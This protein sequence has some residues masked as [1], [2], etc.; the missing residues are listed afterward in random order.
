M[1][2][3][4]VDD[5]GPSLLPPSNH[6]SLTWT[7]KLEGCPWYLL[8]KSTNFEWYVSSFNNPK[9]WQIGRKSANIQIATMQ[10]KFLIT[11]KSLI[12][13]PFIVFL[14][15]IFIALIPQCRI[16]VKLNFEPF[17]WTQSHFDITSYSRNGFI[18]WNIVFL[19]YFRRVHWL[20]RSVHQ[21]V[22]ALGFYEPA[23]KTAFMANEKKSSNAPLECIL[24][25]NSKALENWGWCTFSAKYNHTEILA[26][27]KLW[28]LKEP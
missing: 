4:G 10:C 22:K 2:V 17:S 11:S 15:S 20:Q 23:L 12:K 5:G 16:S 21:T 24:A 3:L 6:P 8:P 13:K 1:E 25:K 7:S 26:S 19:T 18:N 27:Y 9:N 28:N 14:F